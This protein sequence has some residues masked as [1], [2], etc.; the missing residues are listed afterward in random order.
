MNR[1]AV[2]KKKWHGSGMAANE[3][4]LQ[5]QFSSQFILQS[6]SSDQFYNTWTE[7]LGIALQ[8]RQSTFSE[9]ILQLH[10]EAR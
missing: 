9:P 6:G 7:S 5:F 10:L 3:R 2:E 8:M 4:L 1:G